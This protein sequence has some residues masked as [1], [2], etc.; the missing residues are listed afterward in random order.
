MQIIYGCTNCTE[1]LFNRIFSGSN[2][3]VSI[4]AQKYHGLLIKG[5]AANGLN[6]HCLSGLPINRAVTS[7][8]WISYPDE[9]EGNVHYHYYKTLN[10]PFFRQLMIFF[11]A[12][13]NTFKAKKKDVPYAI[14]D[15]L[16]IANAYGMALAC[17]IR[18]IPIVT[19]V[20]DLPDM[21]SSGATRRI[22]NMLFGMVD[23]FILLTEEMSNRVNPKNKPYIVLE[24]HVDSDLTLPS[25]SISYEKTEGKKIIIYAGSLL[26][27]YG[28]Q[29]LTEGFLK[30]DIKDAE[31]HIYGDGDYREELIDIASKNPSVKYMGVRPNAEIVEEEQKA[32]LLVNPR[33][34]APEYTKYSFPSKNMEYM[35][36]GTPVLTTVLPGMPEEYYPYVY[37]LRD[38][39]PEGIAC[40][41]REILLASD[42]ERR[43]KGILAREFVLKEKSNTKQ[44]EKIIKFLNERWGNC[45]KNR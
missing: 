11:G 25:V 5:L 24:G 3:S 18:K 15:C 19:I 41:L 20:T 13:F 45:E 17:K 40:T 22:N 7:K 12:F 29:S 4:A 1:S 28:I 31:L 23:G 2:I 26:K 14:C 37:L 42:E 10:L 21:M 36:S 6:V 35:V 8:K 44:S 9:R 43:E 27:I 38:E 39:S 33:P 32:S 30:A 16:N 34:T